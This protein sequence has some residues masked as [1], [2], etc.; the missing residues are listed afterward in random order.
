MVETNI[1]TES[2][3]APRVKPSAQKISRPTWG[4]NRAGGRA[5]AALVLLAGVGPAPAAAQGHSI[6]LPND[7]APFEFPLA[8]PRTSAMV[9]RVVYV[10]RGES[11]FGAEW[12][13]EPALGE[14]WPLLAVSRGRVPL[15]LHLGSE[16]YGRFSLADK[17]SAL[18]SNDWHVNAILTADLP[19]WRLALEGYHESS[20]LGDEY[21]DKSGVPRVDWSR[22]ILGVWARYTTGPVQLQA[23]ASYAAI[24]TPDVGR[25]TVALAADY[26]GRRGALLGGTAQPI[27]ALYADSH[28]FVDWRLTW[29]GRAG[30]RVADPT[31]RR[32][33]A[34][35]LTFLDGMS[36]QRQFYA[37]KTRYV[38]FEVRF[39]L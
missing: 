25:G 1:T 7:V 11:L 18:I 9:G 14:I 27:L 30:I 31:D 29:S 38:G 16:V 35:L 22:E 23:N 6:F 37:S 5:L 15:N 2:M 33:I 21:R 28:Q 20:H 8:S 12:E 17:S 36:P 10:S 39:D 32:G 3:S 19:H 34:F 26:R 24:S 4:Y 13:A